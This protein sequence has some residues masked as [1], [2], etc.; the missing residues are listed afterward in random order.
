[1]DM[2]PKRDV[3]MSW[4]VFILYVR[5]VFGGEGLERS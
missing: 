4:S 1:M 3:G 2:G 5:Q